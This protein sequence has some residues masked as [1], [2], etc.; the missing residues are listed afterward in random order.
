MIL[1]YGF[2]DASGAGSGST[3][4]PKGKIHYRIGTWS[5]SEDINSSIWR[6]FEN[7]VCEVEEAGKWGG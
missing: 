7:L 6:E 3:L 1:I 2:V 5:S 4:L